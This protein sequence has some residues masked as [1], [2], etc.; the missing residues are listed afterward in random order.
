VIVKGKRGQVQKNFKHVAVDIKVVT[1][2]GV[3]MVVIEMWFGN[4]RNKPVVRTV[5]SAIQNMI[6]GVTK[7]HLYKM[8]VAYA[9]FP[10]MIGVLDKGQKLEIRNFV[11]EKHRK[12]IAMLP[13]C[14]VKME[15][16]QVEKGQLE[17]DQAEKDKKDDTELIKAS[18]I[19]IQGIDLDNVA[20]ICTLL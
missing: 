18:E 2:K 17:K 19:V 14:E 5:A 8:R 6:D 15:K 11:G 10:I 20:L 3:K 16:G 4:Y 9:H 1:V 7:G 12:T 13:G